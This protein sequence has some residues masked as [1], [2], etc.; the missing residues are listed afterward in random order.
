MSPVDESGNRNDSPIALKYLCAFS[1]ERALN[2]N[3]SDIGQGNWKQEG[4]FLI[5]RTNLEI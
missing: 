5:L 1:M 2:I 4:A 3:H